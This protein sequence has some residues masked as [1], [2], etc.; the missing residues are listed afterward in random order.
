MGVKYCEEHNTKFTVF[1]DM[2]G[3]NRQNVDFAF[4]RLINA[5][6]NMFQC[7]YGALLQYV[8][9]LHPNWLFR[10]AYAFCRPFLGKLEQK[11]KM[12]VD[13]NELK[14]FYADDC[15]M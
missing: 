3:Y 10:L 2:A 1:W 11:I 6:S 15:L 5:N 8:C 13:L 4:M 7:S 12:V 14:E 9:I